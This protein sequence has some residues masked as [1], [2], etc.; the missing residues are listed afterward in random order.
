M[1]DTLTAISPLDGR[2][3]EKVRHLETYFSEYA[4]IRYRLFVELEWFIFLCNEVK[5]DGT[6]LLTDAEIKILRSLSTDFEVLDAKRVKEFEATTNHDVKAVEYFIKEHLKA[7]PKLAELG[8]FIHFSCTSEDI[9][10][11]SYALIIKDFCTKEFL[12]VTSGVVVALHQM[13][14]KY[15][16]V[17]M[18]AHTHGQPASPTTVGKELI[19][20]V[21]RLEKQIEILKRVEHTG[22]INGAVGNFNAHLVAYPEVDWNSVSHRFIAYLG[23]Q[24]NPYTTQIEPHDTMAELFDAVA[25]INTI[26]IDLSRDFWMY[27]AMKYFK[28]R[29]KAGE[30][31]S[32]TMPHKVN[33]IDFENAEGNLGVANALLRHMAEKLPI[34]RMQRDLSDSTVERNIGSAFGY[35]VLAYKSLMNGLQKV[36]INEDKLAEDLNDNWEVLTEPIQTVLRKNKIEGAYEKLKELSRGKKLTDKEIS[37]FVKQLKIPEGDKKRLLSLTPGNYTGL[38]QKLVESYKLKV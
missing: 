14:Q 3:R 33:P 9:N 23:L 1:I 6:R 13:A 2:Y 4:L 27:I 11:L 20:V 16:A 35:S 8:E 25:R 24:P 29:V 36:E 18:L 38:A 7:Y 17:P 10:N 30:V 32:S 34:S 19:N 15:K 5:L 31:G 21:A 12:P 28:Q 26:L 22:K 37:A